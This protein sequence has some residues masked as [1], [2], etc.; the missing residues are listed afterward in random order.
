MA[1]GASLS[2]A[3]SGDNSASTGLSSG[4]AAASVALSGFA[5]DFA[6]A[7]LASGLVLASLL[8]FFLSV[9]LGSDF[10]T[11]GSRIDTRSLRP[12]MTTM[13]SGFS[14]ARMPLAAAGQSA[15]SPLGW[16][17]MRPETA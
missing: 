12:S 13:A 11:T 15:G 10:S 8:S 17:L 1:G 3:S 14:M 5:V 16:Y 7:G 2:A 6:S 4:F 9:D